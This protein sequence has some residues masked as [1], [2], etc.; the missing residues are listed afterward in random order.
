M[1]FFKGDKLIATHIDSGNQYHFTCP[2]DGM[3]TK[4]LRFYLVMQLDKPMGKYQF[5]KQ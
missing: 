2:K 3:C 4:M 5:N 1:T